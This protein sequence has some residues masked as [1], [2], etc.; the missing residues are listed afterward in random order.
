MKA[1]EFR[2][3]PNS[4]QEV[5]DNPNKDKIKYENIIF[6]EREENKCIYGKNNQKLC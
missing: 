1:Y 3:Y 6:N 5:T 2:I 4:Q